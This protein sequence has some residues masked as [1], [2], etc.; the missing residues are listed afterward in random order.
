MA[1]FKTS[2]E[3]NK[4]VQAKATKKVAKAGAAT[5][6]VG[7]V[8]NAGGVIIRPHIT[9]KAAIKTG[10]NTYVFEVSPRAT[11]TEVAKAIAAIF[12]VIPR[13]VNIVSMAPRKVAQRQRR[14]PKGTKSGMKKAYVF[15]KKGDKIE[16]V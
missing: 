7:T 2:E 1:L 10:D 3:K 14:G 16:F 8:L 11:K 15:L 6:F 13:K 4:D 12:K 5:Q 9:E